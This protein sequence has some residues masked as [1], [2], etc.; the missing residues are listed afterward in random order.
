MVKLR[1]AEAD[2]TCGK[3]EW[4]K[5]LVQIFTFQNGDDVETVIKLRSGEVDNAAKNDDAGEDDDVDAGGM[6][7]REVLEEE[8][9]I[10]L[11]DSRDNQ[12]VLSKGRDTTVPHEDH[13]L[14]EVRIVVKI[15]KKM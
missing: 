14:I 9:V 13:H 6:T 15:L 1:V 2:R 10:K 7:N 11:V 8:G 12:F 4:H 3:W 5:Y